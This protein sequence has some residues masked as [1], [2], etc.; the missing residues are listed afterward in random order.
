M[1]KLTR[2]DLLRFINE[3][4]TPVTKSEI[5]KAFNVKGA[6]DRLV[7]KKLLKEM[8]KDGKLPLGLG[9]FAADIIFGTAGLFLTWRLL[10]R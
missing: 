4:P 6:E 5:A 1:S 9:C 8:G 3:S 2:E 10:R 7:L